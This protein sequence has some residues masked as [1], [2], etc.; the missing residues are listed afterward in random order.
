MINTPQ[1]ILCEVHPTTVY[2]YANHLHKQHKS[3]LKAHR[4]FLICA[5]GIEAR[6]DRS[7]RNHNGECDGRQF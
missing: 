6:S 3:T 2:G 7:S 5:C 4:I 1:C